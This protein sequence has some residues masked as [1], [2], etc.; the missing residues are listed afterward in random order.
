MC[1]AYHFFC[2]VVCVGI[3]SAGKF[4]ECMH[5]M[6]KIVLHA[7]DIEN[8]KEIDGERPKEKKSTKAVSQGSQEGR[9]RGMGRAKRV[10]QETGH[11]LSAAVES[12]ELETPL[13]SQPERVHQVVATPPALSRVGPKGGAPP[14][15]SERGSLSS[16]LSRHSSGF[17]SMQDEGSSARLEWNDAR[18]HYSPTVIPPDYEAKSVGKNKAHISP[19]RRSFQ[20]SSREYLSVSDGRVSPVD[21]WVS[22][23][24]EPVTSPAVSR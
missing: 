8:R 10:K 1:T 18:L 20:E 2:F 23:P 3:N 17:G 13:P 4:Y 21:A 5:V 16:S 24:R 19:S 15:H 14:L 22:S 12:P 6:K 11:R 7:L 9:A